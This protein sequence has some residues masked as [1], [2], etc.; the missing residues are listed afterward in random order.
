MSYTLF[1][2]P[3]VVT[4]SIFNEVSICGGTVAAID[5]FRQLYLLYI[6]NGVGGIGPLSYGTQDIFRGGIGTT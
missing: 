1:G 4:T 3:T 6:I 5:L 2:T